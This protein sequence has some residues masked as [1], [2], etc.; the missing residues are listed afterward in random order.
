MPYR[1]FPAAFW[2]WNKALVAVGLHRSPGCR[3]LRYLPPGDCSPAQTYPEKAQLYK[4]PLQS[5]VSMDPGRTARPQRGSG[6]SNESFLSDEPYW[7]F[8]CSSCKMFPALTGSHTASSLGPVPQL[9]AEPCVTATGG[10]ISAWPWDHQPHQAAPY[11]PWGWCISGTRRN[12][13][14]RTV[15]TASAHIP[16]GSFFPALIKAYRR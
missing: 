2:K 15:T 16:T 3:R 4:Q 5:R 12:P 7:F 6:G 13:S 9:M 10:G 1:F 14:G 8:L 11:L